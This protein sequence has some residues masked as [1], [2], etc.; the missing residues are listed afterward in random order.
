MNKPL[1]ILSPTEIEIA[2]FREF[3]ISD[4]IVEIS[5]I[6]A[7]ETAART[8]S[9]IAK[10]DPRMIILAGIAGAY[11][12]AG[13]SVGSSVVV[14][15][16]RIADMGAFHEDGFR[17]NFEKEY[18]CSYAQSVFGFTKVGSNSV[19]ACA[20]PFVGGS[21]RYRIENMEGAAFFAVCMALNVPFLELRTISNEVS[22]VR[23]GW[24]IP[25]ATTQLSE[26]LIKLID[27][28]NA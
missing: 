9:V 10:H 21:D 6:G 16:E 20:A 17:H 5:G 12:E 28:I 27:E 4:V 1:I 24:D 11:P 14:D 13:L 19:S 22:C 23:N 8:A 2:P 26:S 3:C 15:C 25:L 7:A 18:G